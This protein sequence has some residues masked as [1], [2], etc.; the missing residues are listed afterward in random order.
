MEE[1][2]EEMGGVRAVAGTMV[3]HGNN[4]LGTD[5]GGC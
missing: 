3:E 2:R 5:H 1:G 4:G